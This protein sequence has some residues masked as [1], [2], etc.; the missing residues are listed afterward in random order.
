MYVLKQARDQLCPAGWSSI[1]PHRRRRVRRLLAL[2]ACGA[3]LLTPTPSRALAGDLMAMSIE[4]L[5]TLQVSLAAR[6]EQTVSEASAAVHILTQDDIRHSGATSVA[7]LLRLVPGMEVARIDANKW[8]ITA[9]GFN[10][11]FANKLLVQIDGRTVYQ[12]SFSGVYWEELD[13]VLDDVERIEVIRGPGATLWGANAV[14]GIVNVVTKHA[15]DTQGSLVNASFGSEDRAIVSLRHGGTWRVDGHYRGYLK[16]ARRDAAA[17]TAGNGAGDGWSTLHAGGRMDWQRAAIGSLHLQGEAYVGDLTNRL[18]LPQLE[19]PFFQLQRDDID[20]FGGHLLGR[21]EHDA[22]GAG[23]WVTQVFY[24]MHDREEFITQ[25]T[26]TFDI[27]IQCQQEHGA[28]QLVWG[29]GYR[30]SWNRTIGSLGL[31]LGARSRT[32]D[33]FSLFV[34]DDVGLLPERLHLILGSK[35]EHNE[36]TGFEAQPSLRLSWRPAAWQTCW[37]G[38][39]RAL[40]TPSRGELDVRVILPGNALPTTLL[41]EGVQA[42]FSALTGNAGLQSEVL[43]A[44]EFG[45]RLLPSSRLLIDVVAFEH[46]Y[47]DLRALQPMGAYVDSSLGA[48]VAILPISF[49]NGMEGTGRGA[50]LAVDGQLSDAVR[51]ALKKAWFGNCTC[52]RGPERPTLV[53][54]SALRG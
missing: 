41:P 26:Q 52:S 3:G 14:N 7:E 54:V 5:M 42:G 8:A 19:P 21:W 46:R 17:D 2:I 22:A 23:R 6:S 30:I 16:Y 10:E 9:R 4:E 49:T 11:R 27:D 39:S 44:F 43:T 36:F 15:A 47:D 13:V 32:A 18:E 24:T 40:R 45:V 53:G 37:A 28:H 33:R 48:L 35:L 38:V 20:I 12:P 31:R 50:E 51:L 25:R 1:V 29:G 34:Q